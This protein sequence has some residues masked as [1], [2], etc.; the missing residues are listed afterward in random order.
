MNEF[1]ET[2]Y[3]RASH[4]AEISRWQESIKEA[5]M[6]LAIEP[7]HYQALCTISRAY[8]H[9]GEMEKA[10]EFAGKAIETDPA[11]EWAYRLQSAVYS[12]KNKK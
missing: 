7:S 1:A 2:Y 6:C 5:G 11:Q 4:L 8:Y 9:L 3:Q 10:L 12:K